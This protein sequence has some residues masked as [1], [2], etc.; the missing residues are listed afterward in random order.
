MT[1]ADFTYV[2]TWAGSVASS[3]P[4]LGALVNMVLK[5]CQIEV[6]TAID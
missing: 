5:I 6:G 4:M 3:P 2:S 1:A